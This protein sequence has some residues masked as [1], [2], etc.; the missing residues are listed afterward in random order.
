MKTVSGIKK[1]LS[2][3]KKIL[4]TKFNVKEMGI[5]GSYVRNE[6]K[7]K[8]DL[9]ILVEF[10]EVPSLFQFIELED[11]LKDILGVSVD[12]VRKK[13]LRKELKE[14]ILSETFEVV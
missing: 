2:Q 12:L 14:I 13:A 5:F 8:S 3:H 1:I 4:Q 10:K 6:Q 7:A 11:Y 9:D